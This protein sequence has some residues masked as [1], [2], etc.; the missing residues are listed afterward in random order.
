MTAAFRTSG[1]NSFTLSFNFYILWILGAFYRLHKPNT[2]TFRMTGSIITF[3]SMFME[4]NVIFWQNSQFHPNFVPH[5]GFLHRINP[6]SFVASRFKS[7]GSVPTVDVHLTVFF[8]VS[9]HFF[10]L[11]VYN[12]LLIFFH[13]FHAIYPYPSA[14]YPN[15]SYSLASLCILLSWHIRQVAR[16]ISPAASPVSSCPWNNRA[17]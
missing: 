3:F 16:V 15:Q 6:Y 2:V 4:R 11:R 12:L 5:T 13:P 14:C 1:Q 9:Q 10:F 17:R 7:L 8:Q